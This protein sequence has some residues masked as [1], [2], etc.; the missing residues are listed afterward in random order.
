MMIMRYS[1]AVLGSL[2]R[3]ILVSKQMMPELGWWN[4]YQALIPTQERD[5]RMVVGVVFIG[6]LFVHLASH[7][8]VCKFLHIY[9][10]S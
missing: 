10:V 6:A 3:V 8:Y 9:F 1:L 2:V 4:N 7:K 5:A